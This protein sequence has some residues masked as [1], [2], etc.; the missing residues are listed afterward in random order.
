MKGSG[1]VVLSWHSNSLAKP[2]KWTSSE[3]FQRG[4]VFVVPR[5][6]TTWPQVTPLSYSLAETQRSA[7]GVGG[8]SWHNH[9]ALQT[10]MN[11][12]SAPNVSLENTAVQWFDER[13]R[14]KRRCVKCTAQGRGGTLTF[15]MCT[16][17]CIKMCLCLCVQTQISETDMDTHTLIHRK[18]WG[19]NEGLG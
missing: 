18:G 13:G 10:Q 6:K 5:T 19:S 2:R 14:F 16:K 17:V 11:P 15:C 9:A 12:R 3:L 8:R 4:L 7:Q 1:L